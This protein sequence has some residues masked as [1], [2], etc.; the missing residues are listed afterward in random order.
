MPTDF[1]YENFDLGTDD[2]QMVTVAASCCTEGMLVRISDIAGNVA[3]V[4]AKSSGSGTP[5]SKA[6]MWG[7]IGGGIALVILVRV[8][9]GKIGSPP[10]G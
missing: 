1:R 10:P 7:L 2:E 5:M 3:E 9:Q 6:L 4:E 8:K